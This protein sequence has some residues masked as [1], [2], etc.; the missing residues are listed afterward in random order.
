MLFLHNIS[1]LNE[2]HYKYIIIFFVV[3]SELLD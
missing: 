3:T 1:K 2:I